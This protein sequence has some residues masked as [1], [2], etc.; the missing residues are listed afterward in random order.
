MYALRDVIEG[1][2]SYILEN[3]TLAL[4]SGYRE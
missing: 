2:Y 3:E 4:K 1:N